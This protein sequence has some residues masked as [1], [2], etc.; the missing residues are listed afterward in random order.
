MVMNTQEEAS[1]LHVY[2]WRRELFVVWKSVF[3]TIIIVLLVKMHK[4]GAVYL[5]PRY[6]Y[7]TKFDRLYYTSYRIVCQLI[8]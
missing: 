5:I 7:F 3:H 8:S 4:I 1:V 6:L 2:R